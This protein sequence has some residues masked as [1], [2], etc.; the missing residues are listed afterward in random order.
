[1]IRYTPMKCQCGNIIL[2]EVELI[3]K[4]RRAST[5]ETCYFQC[6][7][8]TGYSNARN[9]RDR[10]RIM[11]TPEMNVPREIVNGLTAILR[12]TLNKRNRLNKQASFCSEFSEDAVTWTVFSYLA[13]FNM[14][15]LTA[16]LGIRPDAPTPSILLWGAPLVD[17]SASKELRRQLVNAS[18]TLNEEPLSRTEPDVVIAWPNRVVFIEVKFNSCNP[19]QPDYPHFGKYLDEEDI[20]AVPTRK[21]E[22]VG[23]YELVRNWRIGIEVAGDRPFMLVNLG[24]NKIFNDTVTFGKQVRQ[25]AWW[26][27]VHLTWADLFSHI[28]PCPG[29]LEAFIE[30]RGLPK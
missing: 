5:Y 10:R 8:G 14:S 13:K 17:T 28:R 23:Y 29:W 24:C 16:A 12:N 4:P 30:N 19:K 15:A 11:K 2:P 27:F 25:T 9:H 3:E 20:F 6:E 18:D 7:C 22:Q 1:M 21:V 26:K